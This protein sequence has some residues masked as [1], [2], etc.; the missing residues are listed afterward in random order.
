MLTQDTAH[1]HDHAQWVSRRLDRPLTT[2]EACLVVIVCAACRCGP[3]D[4][5]GW[6]TR[7]RPHGR[8]ARFSISRELA[9]YDT[10]GLTRLVLAAHDLRCRVSVEA[11][12]PRVLQV[13]VWTRRDRTGKDYWGR[14][15][16]MEDALSAWREH[17]EKPED[18]PC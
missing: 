15:P 3:Y 12:A 2:A 7:L 10:D 17:H 9:T 11:V 6:D 18:P 14:H 4:L 1:E 16:Q 5:K 8:G 13:C